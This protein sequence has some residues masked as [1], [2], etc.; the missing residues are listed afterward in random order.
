MALARLL[1]RAAEGTALIEHGALADLCCF[2]YYNARAVVDKHARGDFCGGVN[3]YARP[4]FGVL[5]NHARKQFKA[6]FVQCV[7]QPVP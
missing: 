3:F 7:P 1:A 2:S 6:H 4:S 5:G